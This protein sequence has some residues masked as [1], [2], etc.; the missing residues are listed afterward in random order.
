MKKIVGPRV[1]V[2]GLAPVVVNTDKAPVKDHGQRIRRYRRHG[3]HH[4]KRKVN[5]RRSKSKKN[6]KMGIS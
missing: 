4:P 1:S 2:E 6:P 3:V 5:D